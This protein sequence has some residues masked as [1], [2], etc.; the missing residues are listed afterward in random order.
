MEDKLS[1]I[2]G[3]CDSYQPLWKN[4]DIL[5]KRYWNLNTKQKSQTFSHLAFFIFC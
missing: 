4:F 5:F 1:V 2:I 3:S